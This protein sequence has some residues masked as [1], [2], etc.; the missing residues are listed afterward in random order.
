[1]ISNSL[2]AG[3]SLGQLSLILLVDLMV[4]P[5]KLAKDNVPLLLQVCTVL[6]DHYTLLV[7][8]QARE[9]LVHLIHELVISKLDDGKAD[10]NKE[11]VESFVER[12]RQH[13]AEVVWNYD[14]YNGKDN[15]DE[16]N[17]IP[18]SMEFMTNE[19]INIFSLT[20]PNIH[21]QWA[22]TTLVWATSCPVRHL[23]CRSFQIFR[24]ILSSL[25]QAML[26]DMLARLSN[27]IADEATDI[28]TFSME[29]LTTL[30]TIIGALEAA[31]LLKYPQLFWTTCACLN[32]VIEREFMET[33]G[34]L[35]KLLDKVNLT[36]PAVVR[37][38]LEAKPE[39]WE[40][41]FDGLAPL[42][43]KGLKS[44][45]S[46]H[47]TLKVLNKVLPLPD[48][49]LVGIDGRLLLGVLANLPCFLESFDDPA[50][51]S[52]C[53]QSAQVLAT[54]AEAEDR[55]E[56]SAVLNAY[57]KSR[58]QS[59]VDFLHQ[60]LYTLRQSF[61]P[62]WEI[63]SLIFLM[64]L[65]TNRVSFYKIKTM[66]LLCAM[67]PEIDMH[68]A[69]VACHGP[70]LI[71]PLLRLLQTEYC[72]QALKVMD[73]I[74]IMMA[75]TPM[76]K[77]H[78]RMSMP[79]SGSRSVRKEYERTQS[80]YG[81]PEDSGWSI[82][83]PAIHSNT[84]RA[85]VH[86]V[87]YTCASANPGGAETIP[88]PEIEFHA[89]ENP[90]PSYFTIDRAGG[91]M[92]EDTRTEVNYEENTADL[93]SKLDS[94][95]DFFEDSLVSDSRY[96][97][98][99]SDL[100][101][102]GYESTPSKNADLYDQQ[103][104]PILHKSLARTPSST[105]LHNTFT[106][107]RGNSFR[108]APDVMTP[109]AFTGF[110]STAPASGNVGHNSSNNG[111]TSNSNGGPTSA[112][113]LNAQRPGL[114]SRSITSPNNPFPITRPTIS[115]T[116][117]FPLSDDEE[118]NHSVDEIFSD[119]ERSTGN[120]NHYNS[121]NATTIGGGGSHQPFIESMIRR[122][123]STARKL[124]PASSASSAAGGGGSFIS[125][126]DSREPM[127]EH[128]DRSNLLARARSKSQAPGSPEVPKVPEAFLL[129]PQAKE[130]RDG[131]GRPKTA[132]GV[133]HG[134]R[135]I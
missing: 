5:V 68:R 53:F 36:D 118:G 102:T 6:W 113:Q 37:I 4:A 132:G 123:K 48:N 115:D 25:D 70:D 59:G 89:E 34:M 84:T 124:T 85:N 67:I 107:I 63:K 7:Q 121:S 134:S 83:M 97:S 108:E 78:L 43:Y 26:A 74:M 32:T 61:F 105:S 58:Y 56:I 62:F 81:I 64:G 91:M 2:Q 111:N 20:Y 18:T 76:D 41:S 49:E 127:R 38:L 54:V 22:K 114:H 98:N 72:P 66:D 16:G 23:A 17:R 80:L 65:L 88:T 130:I 125:G 86:A 131:D 77:H 93:V 73:H 60:M 45:K 71:S 15:E 116:L 1:M 103:T 95:D 117:S 28:Q 109:T 57:A 82:P 31:D 10:N 3:F 35:D 112:P 110:T 27:T 94:L 87:F 9:M 14:E 40:G 106:D 29:I 69:E 8:E 92:S 129:H 75:A 79:S 122:T 19:V 119:D 24:C 44:E 30:K 100:T 46:L 47:R 99:Y 50:T 51:R 39:K 101:L 11:G 90:N 55:H 96:H 21:E 42:I 120:H 12:I 104:A 135:E 13:K 52:D 33:L 133:E 126:R 128:R